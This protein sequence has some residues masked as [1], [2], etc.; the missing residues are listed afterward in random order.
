MCY[1]ARIAADYRKYVRMFG[2][3]LSVNDFV[4]L[5]WKRKDDAG[6]R[7]PKAMETPFAD[8]TSGQEGRIRA[9]I[10]EYISDQKV[11]YE[12]EVFKQRTRLADA[13]RKLAR[14]FHRSRAT[15]EYGIAL[16]CPKIQV[17]NL[18]QRAGNAEA[19]L[20]RRN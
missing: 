19:K 6:V 5:F 18:D 1:S 8:A 2:A 17:S 20:Y 13:E 12:Q 10:D 3:S 16:V 4:D 14:I 15:N 7:I 11:R 9:L